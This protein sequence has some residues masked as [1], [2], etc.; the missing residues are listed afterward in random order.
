MAQMRLWN[1]LTNLALI[2]N[3]TSESPLTSQIS[4]SN[5]NRLQIAAGWVFVIN[6]TAM[7]QLENTFLFL[8]LAHSLI[9]CLCRSTIAPSLS[10]S[11]S[12]HPTQTKGNFFVSLFCSKDC[13]PE[14][15]VEK[16]CTWN[17]QVEDTTRIIS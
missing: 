1:N 3:Q 14:M 9:H 13:K 8:S 15:G 11:L 16:L 5:W 2:Q 12:N 6:V 17:G 10:L 4:F 7:K